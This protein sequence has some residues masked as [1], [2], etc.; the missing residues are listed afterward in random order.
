MYREQLFHG[1][2][3][4]MSTVYNTPAQDQNSEA[5]S[6]GYLCPPA[7]C[8]VTGPQRVWLSCRLQTIWGRADPKTGLSDNTTPPNSLNLL[9]T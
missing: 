4:L 6:I 1:K 7:D 8:P 2:L 5:L 3:I 9:C